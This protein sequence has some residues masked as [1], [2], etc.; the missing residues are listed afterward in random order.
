MIYD[1]GTWTRRVYHPLKIYIYVLSDRSCDCSF[2]VSF[3]TALR[4]YSLFIV[5]E[6][7]INFSNFHLHLMRR[8]CS[9]YSWYRM[10]RTSWLWWVSE[11]GDEYIWNYL[12]YYSTAYKICCS[13]CGIC[14]NVWR[15][16]LSHIIRRW[17]KNKKSKNNDYLGPCMS[18]FINLSMDT[19]KYP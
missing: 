19:H 17:G 10:W 1:Y 14:S 15:N 7:Y 8:L 4:L 2:C 6:I 3:S 18:V 11:F 12:K 9:K 5:Y 16:T 13:I